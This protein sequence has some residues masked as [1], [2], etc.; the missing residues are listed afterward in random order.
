MGS[1]L[2]EVESN[3]RPKWKDFADH[4]ITYKGNCDQWKSL[5]IR[6]GVLDDHLESAK[7]RSKAAQRDPPP[8]RWKKYGQDPTKDLQDDVWMSANRGQHLTTAVLVTH[9]E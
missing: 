5:V 3:E 8:A 9:E 7:G 1:N 6:D 2:W 4:S